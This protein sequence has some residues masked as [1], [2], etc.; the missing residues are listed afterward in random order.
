MRALVCKALGSTD[1]LVIEEWPDPKAGPGEVVVDVHAAG[2][3]FP[4]LLIVAGK[5]QD[6]S[7]PPF[8][9]GNEAAGVVSQVGEGVSHLKPGDRV[10]AMPRGGAFADKV[11]LSAMQVAPLPGALDFVSGAGFGVTYGTSYHA[12]KQCA[13]LKPGE[14]VL[15]L[16]A[17]GG[18]G[19]AAVAIA[20]AM[21]ARVIAAASDDGKLDF[22]REAGADDA[23]NYSE[24]S[25]KDATRA[26][27]DGK[28]VDV[29]V[30]PVGG[31]YALQA[32]RSLAWHGRHLVIGFAAGDIPAFPANI[33][34]LKEARI[35]GVWWGTWVARHLDEHIENM[36]ELA[37][38]L[39][40]GTLTPP[41]NETYPLDQ[42]RA[43]FRQLSQRRAR[44]KV[45]LELGASASS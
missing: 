39:D 23:I 33:A 44:G 34:L 11:A 18:V 6:R 40:D 41:A 42:Y 27:T 7:E 26:L 20:R 5:Y 29:V 12:L 17:A 30:D 36:R 28:G 35:V 14:N 3:N 9:P 45:V 8:V 24:G 22:A 15:V 1:D 4:D 31:D 2:I 25:L 10:I 32:L 13:E 19:I 21:G 38:W 37:E 16:G 43:A